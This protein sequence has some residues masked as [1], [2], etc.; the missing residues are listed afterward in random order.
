MDGM[1]RLIGKAKE[2]IKYNRRWKSNHDTPDMYAQL[3]SRV[4]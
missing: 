3:Q 2:E 1:M 4:P